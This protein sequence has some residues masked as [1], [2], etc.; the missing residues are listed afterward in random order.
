MSITQKMF[1]SILPTAIGV[2]DRT[3]EILSCLSVHGWNA[4]GLFYL[5]I[6]N[7]KKQWDFPIRT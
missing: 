2:A 4:F 5:S 1:N 3:T 6:P 7:F